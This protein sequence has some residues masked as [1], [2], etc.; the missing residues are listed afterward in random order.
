MRIPILVTLATLLAG[1][2]AG[3]APL[4]VYISADM[5]GVAGVAT[6]IQASGSGAEYQQ[7]RRLMT[8]E[9]NAAI[10]GAFLA[11]ATEVLVADSHGNAQNIDLELLDPRARLIRAWPRA[12][13]MAHGIDSSFAAVVFVGYHA[14]E[15]QSPGVLAHTFSGTVEVSLNGRKV[16]EAGFAGATAGEFGVPVVFVSGDQVI[17]REARELFGPIEVAVV[18]D[19]IGFN[20][21]VMRHPDEARRMITDGVRRGVERRGSIRPFK[22]TRPVRMELRWED[23]VMTEVLTLI[24]GV[25]RVDGQTV[26][27]EGK[28]MIDVARIFE[29]VHHIHPPQ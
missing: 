5:E 13:G 14:S 7:Y 9:V 27:Y 15:G 11:G 4:K 12:L 21:A 2:V 6:R 8:R 24:P 3:Q 19:A 28:D 20:A 17:A 10:E 29:V 25:T 22:L 16:P 23:P 18:K 1:P 26:R